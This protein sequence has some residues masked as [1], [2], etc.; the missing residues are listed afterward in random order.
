VGESGVR[1]HHESRGGESRDV[2][3]GAD[4]VFVGSSEHN[5]DAKGRLVLPAKFRE[6]L[7]ARA[8]LTFSTDDVLQLWT[9]AEFHRRMK[10]LQPDLDADEEQMRR[11]RRLSAN[12]SDVEVEPSQGRIAIPARLRDLANLKVGQR[13]VISGVYTAIEL[14]NPKD[15]ERRV[16]TIDETQGGTPA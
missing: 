16:L 11:F 12:S 10:A 3:T 7:G 13:V 2:G 6:E 15:F 1:C 14:W 4:E 5:L 9:D 8:Y